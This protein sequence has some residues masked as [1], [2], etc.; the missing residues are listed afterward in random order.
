MSMGEGDFPHRRTI[1]WWHS[2]PQV[3]RDRPDS[4]ESSVLHELEQ[5]G[6]IKVSGAMYNLET[7]AEDF[8]QVR[9]G[10]DSRERG[11]CR[12][13]CECRSYLVTES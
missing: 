12:A 4:R 13:P 3:K 10:K 9:R 6:A 8:F 2:P 7:A 5:A 1:W 11:G